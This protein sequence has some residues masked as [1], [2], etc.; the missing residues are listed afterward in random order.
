MESLLI[1]TVAVVTGASRGVG[2]GVAC[3]LGEQ[4][5]TVYITGRSSSVGDVA[6]PTELTIDGTAALVQERGGIGIPF[7]C[8][9]TQDDQVKKLFHEVQNTHPQL[10]ILVNN[11][12]GGAN[13]PVSDPNAVFW[14]Q[15]LSWWDAMLATGP[16]SHLVSTYF[17]VPLLLPH[18]SGLIVYTAF[19]CGG[20][21]APLFYDVCMT[22]ITRM[23]S[24][25]AHELRDHNIT[26]VAL[27]PGHVGYSESAEYTGRAVVALALDPKRMEKTGQVL[28]VSDLAKEYGFTDIDGG[29]P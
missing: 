21:T 7:R 13:V 8:D 15:P 25:M 17:G 5:A 19:D 29:Q 1:D 14:K 22:A 28:R 24:S 12:W 11:A 16:R 20:Y 23:A 4:G 9:H 2:R 18:R 3:A 6:S 10:S 27:S 26:V